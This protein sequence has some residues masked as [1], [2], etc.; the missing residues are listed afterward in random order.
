MSNRISVVIP[1]LNEE[2]YLP[3]TLESLKTLQPAASDVIV[4]DGGSQDRTVEFAT[5][6]G[7]RVVNAARGRAK[8]MN[9]GAQEAQGD[10]LIFLHAD[11]QLP[12]EAFSSIESTLQDEKVHGGCFQL[13]FTP[14]EMSWALQFYSW[15]T[16][17]RLFHVGSL[18][19]GDRA[20]FVRK[21]TFEQM[22]GYE[23]WP[24]LEDVDF[25]KRLLRLGRRAFVFV[26]YTVT[27]SSRRFE[28][29]G[30]IRQQLLNLFILFCWHIGISLD[31]IQKL[32]KYPKVKK[33]Q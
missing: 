15:V 21:S 14:D 23:E 1:A 11:T 19:F 30:S 25:A 24:I 18:V 31:R 9:L 7:A 8:Q 5:A 12:A 22:K 17:C 32:Y 10:I 33:V 27:T 13:R 29:L 20:I 2:L 3:S 28:E 6:G 16:K 4:V 26:P